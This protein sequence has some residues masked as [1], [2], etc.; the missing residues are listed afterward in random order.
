MGIGVSKLER[1]SG[2]VRRLPNVVVR[3]L[4]LLDIALVPFPLW[5]WFWMSRWTG[6]LIGP[7][8]FVKK[9]FQALHY[10]FTHALHFHAGTGPLFI[11]W[12]SGPVRKSPGVERPDWLTKGSCGSCRN[13][14]TTAWLPEEK[15]VSCPFLLAQGGC[16][17]YGGL[18]W[19]YFTCGRYPASPEKVAYYSCPR[20]EGLVQIEPRKP[21]GA[22]SNAGD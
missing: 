16:G 4:I 17:V 12:M 13:C 9:Y 15:R 20:F 8:E 7:R 11:E 14:C 1:L 19:D 22:S 6:R 10:A 21:V 2:I 18:F 3:V 5:G